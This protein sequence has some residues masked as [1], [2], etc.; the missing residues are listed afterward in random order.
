MGTL[1]EEL[2][3]ALKE[4]D[5]ELNTTKETTMKTNTE[6]KMGVSKAT[7]YKIQ[8][9]PGISYKKAIE[10]LVDEGFNGVSVYTLLN[11]YLKR[12]IFNKDEK[13]N[14]FSN[15]DY[16]M[17]AISAKKQIKIKQKEFKPKSKPMAS[18][19]ENVNATLTAEYIL[20]NIN[21]EEGLKLWKHLNAMLGK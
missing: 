11:K 6:N 13:G 10:E 8:N 16:Y 3:K 14:M 19:R 17:P 9:N 4:W 15:A 21:M 7:F 1:Q 2:N 18:T 5:S 12:G 20:A